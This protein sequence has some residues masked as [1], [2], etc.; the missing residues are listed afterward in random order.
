MVG[1]F[2]GIHDL[3]VFFNYFLREGMG[4]GRAGGLE[5]GFGGL[6]SG[7]PGFGGGL[8]WTWGG[9]WWGCR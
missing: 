6:A 8:G 4:A 3:T 5:G 2:P 9:L 7:R 1:Y